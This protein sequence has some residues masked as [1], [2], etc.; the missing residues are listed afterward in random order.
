MDLQRYLYLG[1]GVLVVI[2]VLYKYYHWR[3]EKNE[4]TTSAMIENM[5]LRRASLNTVYFEQQLFAVIRQL[6]Y[7]NYAQDPQAIPSQNI[8]P[9]IYQQTYETLKREYDLGVRKK[10]NNFKMVKAKVV[11]QDNSSIYSV[12]KI[13]IEGEFIVDYHY[14]HSTLSTH[15]QK[16]F[17]QRFVFIND[18]NAWLL[19][20]IAK[21]EVDYEEK[22]EVYS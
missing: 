13:E 19:G 1:A 20:E 4:A 9:A 12:T 8:L 22:K 5:G 16:R 21:E 2:F 11:K 3:K 14:Y 10:L 7:S 15:S 17:R 6:V 18:N